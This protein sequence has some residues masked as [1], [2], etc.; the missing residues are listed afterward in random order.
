MGVGV[1]VVPITVWFTLTYNYIPDTSSHVILRTTWG[2]DILPV[3][4]EEL[5]I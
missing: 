1:T 5:V 3:T 2:T 4:S